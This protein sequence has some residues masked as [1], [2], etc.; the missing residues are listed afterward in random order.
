[1]PSQNQY[2]ATV[3]VGT[4]AVALTK[5]VACVL[6]PATED[7]IALPAGANS[8]L[9]YGFA[10]NDALAGERVS[11]HV[12]GGVA[13]AKLGATVAMGDFLM[14]NGVLGDLKTMVIGASNQYIVGKALRGG[15]VGDLIPIIPLNSL[16]QGA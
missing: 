12:A 3:V 4:A 11:L 1:M 9:F 7:S 10:L 6:V 16:A 8:A 13:T 5:G 14:I 15:V 2:G